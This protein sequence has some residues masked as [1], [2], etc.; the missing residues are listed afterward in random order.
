[1]K[2][3]L[4]LSLIILLIS[5]NSIGQFGTIS[6]IVSDEFGPLPGAKVTLLETGISNN[7]D[8]NGSFSFKIKPGTYTLEVGYLLFGSQTETVTI[9][10]NNLNAIT[11]FNL[12]SRS[13]LDA[14]VSLGSRSRPK[15]Q[16][17]NAVAVD[18]ISAT[19]IYNCGQHSLTGVLQYWVPSFHST[20]QTI[21]DGTDHMDPA[22]IRGLGPDQLLVLVNGK[23]L[24]SS[25]LINVNG[26]VGRG[27]VGID[28]NAI[29]VTSIDRIEILRDGAAAQYG[30]DAIAGVI[31]IILKDRTNVFS[32]TSVVHPTLQGDGFQKLI[33]AN[34]GIELGKG[35][36]LSLSGELRDRTAV[37]RA[38]NFTGNVYNVN[39]SIDQLLIDQNDFYG[40][41]SE[42]NDQQIMQIGSAK[43]QDGATFFNLSVPASTKAE[44][45]ANGGVNLRNGEGRGFYRLPISSSR[46]VHDLYPNGFSP[47]IHSEILNKT[48]TIGVQG[49]QNGWN[50]DFNNSLGSNSVDLT[51]K[52]SNNASLG[53]SSP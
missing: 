34:Y 36:F 51:V 2:N 35:G 4:I 27:T 15:T 10:F 13:A 39:D 42:Y 8:I 11:N 5:S 45:Y 19:D 17:E 28:F 52:N 43:T 24:H 49:E 50:I 20:V 30:S 29:P 9:S 26:T 7:C 6:G 48:I 37:N 46:V 18:I 53:I 25:A 16:M 23:R 3:N 33:G 1:M 22:T 21:S 41:L 14:G 47:E 31:N 44:I 12:V 32:I 40:K 38:G